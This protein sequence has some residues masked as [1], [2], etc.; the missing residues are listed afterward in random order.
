M[1]FRIALV[2]FSLSSLFMI[3][4]KRTIS[5]NQSIV[6]DKLSLPGW[7]VLHNCLIRQKM[8]KGK[9]IDFEWLSWAMPDKWMKD[10]ESLKR[11]DQ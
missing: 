7:F 6:V 8:S 3:L 11:K 2:L 9:A 5:K 1:R 4:G 10:M